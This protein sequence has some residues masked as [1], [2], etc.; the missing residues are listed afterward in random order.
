MSDNKEREL[1]S[2]EL[3]GVTGGK[4][5]QPDT[6]KSQRTPYGTPGDAEGKPVQIDPDPKP[7]QPPFGSDSAKRK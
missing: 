2:E 4:A 5:A 3:E 6:H 1:T 7:E